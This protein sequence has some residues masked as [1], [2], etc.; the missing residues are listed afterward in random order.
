M[1]NISIKPKKMML[2]VVLLL[3]IFPSIKIGSF[4]MPVLYLFLPIGVLMFL[5]MIFGWTK[6]PRVIKYLLVLMVLIIIEI[7]LSA[8]IGTIS[9]YGRFIFPTDIIQYVAR[10]LCFIS[11]AIV[12]YYGKVDR[13]TF[14]KYFLIVLNIGMLIGLLQWIPWLGRVFFI[15]LYPFRDGSLQLS[16]LNRSLGNLR[17]HGVA[18]MATGNGGLAS[19]FFIFACSI[20]KYYKKH[21]KASSLLM[22]LSVVNIFASMARAGL[23]ALV[24]GIFLFYILS[25]HINSKNLK[26][27]LYMILLILFVLGVSWVLYIRGNPFIEMTVFRWNRLFETKGGGRIDQL[28]YFLSLFK[29]GYHY[30]FGLSKAFINKSEISYGVEIEPL[31]IFVTYGVSGFILQYSLILG[32]LIYFFKNINNANNEK[33]SLALLVSSFV[34]LFSYQVFSIGYYFFREIHVGLFPW[35][36]MGVAI[37]VFEREKI[38][39]F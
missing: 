15:K 22:I 20:Y 1:I 13:D 16:Q 11:F 7:F 6:V 10:F 31:N 25:M 28:K 33:A 5:T 8:M 21:K 29:N 2:F 39:S 34:G 17:M 12:F 32:L 3:S 14:I 18:Q 26:P 35:I 30:I 9:N 23:L 19:F 37:G 27:T 24:F 4:G 38:E 36:L